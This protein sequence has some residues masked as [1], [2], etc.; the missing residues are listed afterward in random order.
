MPLG[1][2]RLPERP[3]RPCAGLPRIPQLGLELRQTVVNCDRLLLESVPLSDGPSAFK[4]FPGPAKLSRAQSRLGLVINPSAFRGFALKPV[5]LTL[6]AWPIGFDERDPVENGMH[7]PTIQLL[8]NGLF[9]DGF[10]LG[11]ACGRLIGLAKAPIRKGVA[12]VESQGLLAG[13]D[14]ILQLACCQ[15]F[16]SQINEGNEVVRVHFGPQFVDCDLLVGFPG[17]GDVVGCLNREL[18]PLGRMLAPLKSL[19]HVVSS[20]IRLM[21]VVVHRS[22]TGIGHGEI[23]I[24]FNS[25]LEKRKTFGILA[26]SPLLDSR[27]K[28]LQSGE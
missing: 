19:L 14:R 20:K 21:E 17:Y 11:E 8:C 13:L 16:V 6:H 27:C 5:D 23:R 12:G 22:H 25:H 9:T 4:K 28:G 15:V 26:L 18:F 2:W 7:G 24:Q 1:I 3:I 10:G